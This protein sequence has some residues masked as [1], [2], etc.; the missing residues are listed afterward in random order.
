[1]LSFV[2]EEDV[3]ERV[4]ESQREEPSFPS[5]GCIYRKGKNSTKEEEK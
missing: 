4:K 3:M 2:A 5:A 1:M